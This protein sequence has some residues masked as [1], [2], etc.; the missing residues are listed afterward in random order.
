MLARCNDSFNKSL[1]SIH[2]LWLGILPRTK[3]VSTLGKL[4]LKIP[5]SSLRVGGRAWGAPGLSCW[6]LRGTGGGVS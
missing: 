2:W 6:E 1:L 4:P 3:L 5:L